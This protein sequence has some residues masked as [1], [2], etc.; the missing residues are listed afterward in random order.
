MYAWINVR[1]FF[2]GYTRRGGLEWLSGN[3]VVC[4][5]AVRAEQA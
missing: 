2:K 4:V 3:V 1:C 5:L